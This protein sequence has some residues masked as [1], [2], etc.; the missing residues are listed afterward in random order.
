MHGFL[1]NALTVRYHTSIWPRWIVIA[2]TM[3]VWFMTMGAPPLI[4]A[5]PPSPS[6]FKR[7]AT[8]PVFNNTS[9]DVETVAEIIAA[10]EDGN[11]L[12]YTDSITGN[13]G[14]VDITDAANPVP[15][16][17]VALGGEPTSVA[18]AGPYA[19]VG[20]NTRPNFLMPSGQ[21]TVVDLASR[22]IVQTFD[23]GG[24]PDSVAVSPDN[25]YAAIA[26][27][28][29]RDEELGD[30]RPP[31]LPGG[32]LV[33]VKLMGTPD[34]WTT[35][36]ISLTG[37]A[38]LFPTDPEPE[39]VAIN[40]NNIAV[41]TL[42]ENN[43]IVLID[44][45]TGNVV[46]HWSAGAV[47]LDAVDVVENGLIELSDT[48]LQ[49]LREPDGVT[50]LGNDLFAT[51]DEGDLDGGSRGFTIYDMNGTVV[52]ASGNTM[53]HVVA[54]LGHYPEARPESK[55]NEPEGVAY[56]V[57][58]DVPYLFV[59]SERS[60]VV[61]VYQ[62][63]SEEPR[64]Q[65]VQA[66]PAGVGPEG[67][68]AIP[69]RGLFVVASEVDARADTIRSTIT[70]YQQDGDTPS[71][72]T[73]Q[74]ADRGDTGLPI[75]WAALSA[76]AADRVS[77]T[78]AYTVYDSFFTQS[79]VFTVDVSQ[80]PALITSEL[81]LQDNAGNPLNLDA[82]GVATRADGGFWI[83]SEGAG[84]VDDPE[85]PVTSANLLVE[86]AADGTVLNQIPLP[87]EVNTLQRRFGFEG[88]AAV[89]AGAAE[90]VYVAIQREWVDDPAG[91]VRIGRYTP[92]TGAWTFFYYPLDEPISPNGGWVGLS[93]IVALN[94]TT[95]AVIERDNQGGS[96]AVIKR[97]YT[98]SIDGLTPQPQGGIFPV[99]A[100]TLVRDLPS[101]L[102]AD[103]G[104]V[105]EKVEGLTVMADGTTWIVTD[106]DGVDGSSGETQ[107]IDL[108]PVFDG[109]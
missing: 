55:G 81:V 34:L 57:Y 25:Q 99:V 23:L 84:S 47:D 6:V 9:I 109:Q 43:H 5:Q 44:L 46:N 32:Y 48:L 85:Q 91:Q 13:L 8:F 102:M 104:P 101:D 72:P 93:E 83:A 2:V 82:E 60:S 63:F 71:Y 17:V 100:K 40:E 108:G 24:Q 18:V 107:L 3:A 86:V 4:F 66:L 45:A 98:F 31:Q 35:Q 76:L 77:P 96:D 87:A 88:V 28:N 39:F 42:Q 65:F 52:F 15:D 22:M 67:L 27:E 73:I 21:L 103:H 30:G 61:A 64:L 7:L 62:L 36:V 97:I 51:A 50:W 94:E 69:A 58:G 106:N 78:T 29:E 92:A 75:P 16:G 79:R 10:T 56:G 68:L 53:E 20:V 59:G 11:L 14:F 33:V 89:G 80:T 70:I 105:L 49:V 26:I 1:P 37:L 19:L 38:P 41:V 74:S 90:Q 95:F 54:R 12:V